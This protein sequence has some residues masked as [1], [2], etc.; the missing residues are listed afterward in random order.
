MVVGV[1]HVYLT[2]RYNIEQEKTF[3]YSTDMTLY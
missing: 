2:F 1:K 3:L